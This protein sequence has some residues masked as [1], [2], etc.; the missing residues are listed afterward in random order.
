MT[1]IDGSIEK[2]VARRNNEL[3]LH[4]S[5]VGTIQGPEQKEIYGALSEHP[6]DVI[7]SV[8]NNWVDSLNSGK[9]R[10]DTITN[11]VRYGV[12]V[13]ITEAIKSAGSR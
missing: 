1:N 2:I 12:A 10:E 4:L 13:T 6:I 11:P 5:T 3:S 9:V 7:V 8:L